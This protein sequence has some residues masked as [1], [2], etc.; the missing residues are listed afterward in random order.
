MPSP[1]PVNTE[2]PTD[3]MTDECPRCG[4]D[5]PHLHPAVQVG[6]EVELCTH[7]FHL[8]QTG[9]N[10][11]SYVAAVLQKREAAT[12]VAE[13]A[14]IAEVK[15]FARAVIKFHECSN[16]G[17][18]KDCLVFGAIVPGSFGTWDSYYEALRILGGHKGVSGDIPP[19]VKTDPSP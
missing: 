6:G 13:Y 11:P 3:E 4:S 1:I 7:D 17:G 5:H 10:T 12:L 15:R 8:T 9:Q 14:A 19:P 16:H 18:P 2:V